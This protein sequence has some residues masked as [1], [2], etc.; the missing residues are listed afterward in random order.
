[1]CACMLLWK[2]EVE[3]KARARSQSACNCGSMRLNG[4][5]GPGPGVFVSHCG[6]IRLNG[7]QGHGPRVLVSY[8]G[9][10]WVYRH[11]S[12]AGGSFVFFS[13]WSLLSQ[14]HI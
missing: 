3:W 9:S 8:C 5:Q 1:M 2:H 6:S 10:G 11:H 4:T 14:K 13:S 7:T 12:R